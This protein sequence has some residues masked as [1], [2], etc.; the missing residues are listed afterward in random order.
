MTRYLLQS[1]QFVFQIPVFAEKR[2][3]LLGL[4]IAH[5]LGLVK[6]VGQTGPGLHQQAGVVLQLLQLPQSVSILSGHSALT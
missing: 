5:S 1:V 6:G 3:S 2:N 4:V